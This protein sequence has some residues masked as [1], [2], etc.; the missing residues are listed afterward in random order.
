M[1]NILAS[2][3]LLE[4]IPD[5]YAEDI[6]RAAD[7]VRD[8]TSMALR[9]SLRWQDFAYDYYTIPVAP[10]AFV[11]RAHKRIVEIGRPGYPMLLDRNTLMEAE[12]YITLETLRMLSNP[13]LYGPEGAKDYASLVYCFNAMM[14][15]R[16]VDPAYFS[17]L[18]VHRTMSA[19]LFPNRSSHTVPGSGP[20]RIAG[21]LWADM[22]SIAF[23]VPPLVEAFAL[24][25]KTECEH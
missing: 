18:L 3:P 19:L 16:T 10:V 2:I 24:Y 1:A 9:G 20:Y 6:Y 13:K 14:N 5:T 8:A 22:A 21:R 7:F 25:L 12:H 23:V 4:H 15:L 11:I 17:Q